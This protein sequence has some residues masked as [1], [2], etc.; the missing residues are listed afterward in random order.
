MRKL[1]FAASLLLA[2][3][4]SAADVEH[5]FQR[6]IDRGAVQRIFID[7]PTASFTIRNGSANQLALSAIVSR[8]FDG[9]DEKAWAQKV[10]NDTTVEFYVNGKD[11]VIRRKFGPNAQSWRAQKF[12]GLDLR[13]DLPPGVDVQF[14][15]TAGEIDMTGN[16]G[17]IDIDLRAGE[18]DLRM[19]RAMVRELNASCR[20]GEVRTN[21]GTELITKEGLFP[22]TTRFVNPAGRSRVNVHVT[23]GEIDVT[24]T[25]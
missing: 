19:P 10:V 13:L 22:G 14:D 4:A 21:V 12:S 17:N 23:A 20:I 24:L 3:A 2:S 18:I 6:A 25:Q 16:F 7:I 15:T 8:D 5:S 11:A 1:L 9:A